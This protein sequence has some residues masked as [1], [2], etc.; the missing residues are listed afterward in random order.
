[1]AKL[2]L[3]ILITI[4]TY[5][6]E[7]IEPIPLK[8]D[9]DISKALL[10][11]KL[12]FD[13]NLSRDN[14]TSCFSCHDVYKGGADSRV[15]SKGFENREGNI[16][17]PTVFN[18][19]YNFVQYWN[20]R[21]ANLYKQAVEPLK[22]P[23]EHNMDPESIINRLNASN[24]Y[25][26]EFQKVYGESGIAFENVLDAIVEF[27]KALTTPNSKFDKFLRGE[28]TLDKNEHEGY[29]L[30]KKYGCITCHNGINIGGNSYQ[31][32]GTFV[33]YETQEIYPD[34]SQVTQSDMDES[35]FKVPTLRN[36]NLTAPYFHDGS[37]DTLEAA[38]ISMA[39][40]NLGFAIP[41]DDISFIVDFLKTLDGEK[42][43]ILELN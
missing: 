42:P 29:E 28:I 24:I 34:R 23:V 9:Y 36:I 18:A 39:S 30:F 2:V 14:S 12:F 16:Q 7:P 27:E 26:K 37:A 31:K 33:K 38:V 40:Y 13:T 35:V 20:G 6:K 25:K 8:S 17:A 22:N 4:I 10:G 43:K 1:M 3:L 41:A 21:A 15:V 5:A 32:M 19:K 11:K